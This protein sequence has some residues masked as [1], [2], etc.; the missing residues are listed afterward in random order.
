LRVTGRKKDLLCMSHGNNVAPQPIEDAIKAECLLLSE[1]LVYGEGRDVL[2]ALVTL[3]QDA[4]SAWAREQAIAFGDAAELVRSPEV[5]GLVARAVER[6]N[7]SQARY[8]QVHRFAILPN[9]FSVAGGELTMTLKVRRAVAAEKYA[10]VIERMYA[11]L[12][13]DPLEAPAPHRP[14]ERCTA[15]D[16]TETDA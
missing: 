6:V 9:G 13:P 8:K 16:D 4:L 15:D 10:S 3:D 7:A 14:E 5:T 1:A 11:E 12:G 2:V